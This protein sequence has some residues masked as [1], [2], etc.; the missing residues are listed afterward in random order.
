MSERQNTLE[1]G[2][3]SIGT[4]GSDFEAP[5]DSILSSGH[6]PPWGRSRGLT[7]VYT[8][9]GRQALLL[10]ARRLAD[11]GICNILVPSFACRSMID[12]LLG[13]GLTLTPIQ[14]RGDLQLDLD[15]LVDSASRQR[16]PFAALTA[17]YFGLE[18]GRDYRGAIE[19]VRASGGFVIDDETHRIFT[20]SDAGANVAIASLRKLLPISTGAYLRG[21]DMDVVV[22]GVSSV[23][24]LR[25]SAMDRKAAVLSG[26]RHDRTYREVFAEANDVLDTAEEPVG[27]DARS[28]RLLHKFNFPKMAELRSSNAARLVE[29]LGDMPILNSSSKVCVPSHVLARV[30]DPQ[31]MQAKLAAVGVFCPIHWPFVRQISN[32]ADWPTRHISIP[33][34]HRYGET[35]MDRIADLVLEFDT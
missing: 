5:G 1:R 8:E 29:Q 23:G 27:P 11:D 9:T 13:A 2:L 34:D 25:W 19:H 12:P 18:P 3:P 21:A 35:D 24:P 22:K 7:T 28:F 32:E 10:L 31:A 26:T 15:S 14:T 4:I 17:L 16:Q 20:A 30:S 33:I 6:L